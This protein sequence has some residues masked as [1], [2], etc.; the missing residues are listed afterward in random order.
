MIFLS[1]VL[2]NNTE[3]YIKYSVNHLYLLNTLKIF[4]NITIPMTVFISFY[5]L[6]STF[7]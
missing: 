6:L 2:L 7:Y 4:L 5:F 3:R 1:L